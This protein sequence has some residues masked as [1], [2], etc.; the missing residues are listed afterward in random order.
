MK[1][2][3]FAVTSAL[4]IA[5][6][7]AGAG[8]AYAN[9]VN[10]NAAEP[11]SSVSADAT[12]HVIHFNADRSGDS[13]LFTTDA[14]TLTTSANQLE[15]RDTRGTVVSTV[16]LTY[17]LDEKSFPIAARVSG[18]TATLTP[19]TAPAQGIPVRASLPLHPADLSTAVTTVAPELTAATAAGAIVGAI[20]GGGGGCIAGA[21]IGLAATAPLAALLGAGPLA[22]CAM[23]ALTLA[24]VGAIAG[25]I[26]VGGPVL[27]A[28]AF[29]FAQLLQQPPK[30]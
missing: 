19:N 20:L 28:A 13:V 23:G 7:G 16:P 22:G 14:G 12:Q 1:I 11:Q 24:P 17:I 26:V 10:S 27:I 9:P 25:S 4:V 30:K 29:Q 2:R 3:T 21:V 18:N 15:I 8:A 5:S 6:A